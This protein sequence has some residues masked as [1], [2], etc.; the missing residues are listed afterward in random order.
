MLRKHLIGRH[1]LATVSIF[2]IAGSALAQPIEPKTVD[3]YL[4]Q[5][6]V[7]AG[8]EWAGTFL[9]LC[10]PPIQA[11][12]A[13]PAAAAAAPATPGL[14]VAGGQ[15]PPREVWF[16]EPAQVFDNLYFIGT[17]IQSA[18]ALVTSDGI[19]L[20]D[21]PPE[22]AHQDVV[23]NG[24]AK[25]GL[26]PMDVKYILISHSHGIG[27]HDGSARWFQDNVPGV[28]VG[29]SALDWTALEQ[30][31]RGGFGI[32]GKPTRDMELTDGQVITLGET[33]V[34]V[35]ATPGHTPGTVSFTFETSNDGEPVA[36][37]YTGGTA[38]NFAGSPAYY[39]TYLNSSI[40]MGEAAAAT[41]ASVF[42]SNHSEF[43]N[44]YMKAN[45]VANRGETSE[46]DPFVVGQRD[47]MDYLG[48]VELCSQAAKLR[49]TGSL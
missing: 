42:L 7:Q 2:C 47:V 39:D 36:V 18:W 13:A 25:L 49:S 20:L 16:A 3:D 38:I 27:D 28:Q 19:I 11:A 26:D 14:G 33:S 6:K 8:L 44:A 32:Y 45:T 30:G 9:R 46:Y 40:L 5:A 12:A 1:L 35:I 23:L 4:G 17:Q 41:G 43:D 22:Y 24:M 48:V 31:T 37:A 29:I 15:I 10:I 34:T 21:N